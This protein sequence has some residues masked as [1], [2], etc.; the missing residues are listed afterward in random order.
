M[1]D[2]WGGWGHGDQRNLWSDCPCCGRPT[3]DA[4][5]HGHCYRCYPPL[6]ELAIALFGWLP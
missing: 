3:F 2:G 1:S 4:G 6:R 5:A